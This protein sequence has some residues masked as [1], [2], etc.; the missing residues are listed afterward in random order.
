[1]KI[2]TKEKQFFGSL[3]VYFWL[4]CILKQVSGWTQKKQHGT[5]KPFA[6]L[7]FLPLAHRAWL[8]DPLSNACCTSWCPSN[9]FTVTWP[10]HMVDRTRGI[11]LPAAALTQDNS[12][13]YIRGNW[14]I[15]TQL[16]TLEWYEILI[17]V[18]LFHFMHFCSLEVENEI[19]L[20]SNVLLKTEDSLKIKMPGVCIRL[21]GKLHTTCK[22]EMNLSYKTDIVSF[23]NTFN[24]NLW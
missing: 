2:Q 22:N 12:A 10:P 9:S 15:K 19:M 16:I 13:A 5:M 1:M 8:P 7:F 21:C 14:E 11:V 6:C 23:S 24:S 17:G 18:S 4:V 20:N 3:I